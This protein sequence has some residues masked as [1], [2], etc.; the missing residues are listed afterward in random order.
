MDSPN[1]SSFY[2]SDNTI[3]FIV[4][5]PYDELMVA[6]I[7]LEISIKM[8]LYGNVNLYLEDTANARIS[9]ITILRGL[10]FKIKM[11]KHFNKVAVVTDR[12]WMRVVRRFERIFLKTE[13][14]VFSTKKR[15]DAIQWISS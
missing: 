14:K 15:I 5:G 12:N 4:D 8:K 2:L 3:G 7:Q 13:I 1:L 10:P 6:A 11:S 9:I